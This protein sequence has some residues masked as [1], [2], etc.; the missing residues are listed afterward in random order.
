MTL[1]E[2]YYMGKKIR[3]QNIIFLIIVVALFFL[4]YSS[5][6][7][8]T[9]IS[10]GSTKIEVA[11]WKILLN[12]KEVANEENILNDV[13]ILIPDTNIDELKPNKVKPGQ[14]GHFDIDINPAST[15]VSIEYDINLILEN[16]PKGMILSGYSIN[17]GEINSIIDHKISGRIELNDSEYLSEDDSQ[18]IRVFWKWNEGDNAGAMQ[19]YSISVELSLRQIIE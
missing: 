6:A 4:L 12:G 16:L 18:K 2:K 8:Y 15:E 11:N 5:L 1:N 7:K 17:S 14:E 9:Y 10:D 3:L 19:D 13:I